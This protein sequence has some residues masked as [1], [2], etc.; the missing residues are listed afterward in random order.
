[1]VGLEDK[2]I[3][4]SFEMGDVEGMTA[5]DIKNYIR[6]IADW[7]LT[8]L[9]LPTKFG[10]FKYDGH[11]YEQIQQHPLPWLTEILNGVEHANFFEQRATEYSKASTQG[12]WEGSAGVWGNF[13]KLYKKDAA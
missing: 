10:Y 3:D 8:Q 4:L 5:Q 12:T 7:R 13:D 6:Y 2:F 11:W 9:R 1:M